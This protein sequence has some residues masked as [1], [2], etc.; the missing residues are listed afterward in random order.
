VCSSDLQVVFPPQ[1]WVLKRELLMI[2]FFG[3]CLAYAHAIAIDRGSPKKALN[4]V[5]SQGR[6]RLDKGIW[7]VIFPEGTRSKPGTS[8]KYSAG[9]AM[10]AS[11]TGYPVVPVAHN[12]GYYWS[13]SRFRLMPGTI[14]IAVGPT[15]DS[16]DRRAG[17]INAE[18]EQWIERT[19][20]EIIP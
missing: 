16:S 18:A 7:V 20:N 3:W 12:A 15:I 2:P 1:T 10:L 11:R 6:D 4:Q 5:I 13:P 17:E 9:G 19:M 8:L 14:K